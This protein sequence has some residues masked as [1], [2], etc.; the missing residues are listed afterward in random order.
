MAEAMS[1][2]ALVARINTLQAQGAE[3]F[4]PV[5]FRFLQRQ[6]ER[7]AQLRNTSPRTLSRLGDTIARLE[8]RLNDSQ[9]VVEQ[10]WDPQQQPELTPLYEQH[11]FKALLRQLAPAPSASPLADVLTLLRQSDSS[12]VEPE[13]RDPLQAM[14][15]EQEGTLFDAADS[16]PQPV[17]DAPRELKAL[18]R[19]RAGQQQQRKRRRIEDALTQTPSDAGPLNSHRLVTR[20]IT[21]LKDL[22]PAYLDHFVTYVDT[23]MVLEK[24]GKKRGG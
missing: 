2:D 4:D 15:Q 5:A 8:Q 16:A 1:L 12:T 19:V 9:Q 14:L 7:L 10:Q 3:H 21:A 17:S 11:A 18:S 22:S 24:S 13:Q 6:S 20:A 23:L